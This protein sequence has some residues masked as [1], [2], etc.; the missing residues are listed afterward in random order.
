[1][2]D[3]RGVVAIDDF[4]GQS[5]VRYV[6]LDLGM[7]MLVSAVDCPIESKVVKTDQNEWRCLR[8]ALEQ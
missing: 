1:M 5:V 4:F 7:D 6:S 2:P 8:V 3:G